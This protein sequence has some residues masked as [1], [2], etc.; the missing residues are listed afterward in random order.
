MF[1]L[2]VFGFLLMFFF[3]F[4]LLVGAW[5]LAAFIASIFLNVIVFIVGAVLSI[6]GLVGFLLFSAVGSVVIIILSPGIIFY[7]A[8]TILLALIIPG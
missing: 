6:I 5:V 2:V 7:F 8:V 4:S 3:L 1:V